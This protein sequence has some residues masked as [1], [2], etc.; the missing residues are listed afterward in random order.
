M[1]SLVKNP[2]TNSVPSE[3]HIPVLLQEVV[4]GLNLA[5][6]VHCLDATVGS[7]GHTRALLT[8]TAPKGRVLGFDRDRSALLSAEE[9]LKEFGNRF[10]GMHD[11]Y[12][13][14]LQHEECQKERGKLAGILIDLGLSSVQLDIAERGF[15]FRFNAPLDMRF[16]QTHG[17]T[18]ADLLNS[19]PEE[20]L[21][22]V[23]WKFGEEPHARRLAAAIFHERTR[24]PFETTEQLV[25]LVLTVKGKGRSSSRSTKVHPA[26]QVFQALRITVN[27]ELEHLTKF[28]PIGLELLS[29][30]GRMAI[31]AY[32]SLEDRIVKQF[33][34]D[35]A[36]D[37]VCPP[38]FP[39]CRCNHRAT[40]RRITR[41]PLRPTLAEQR[42]N[43]RSRSARLRI[44]EKI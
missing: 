34:V 31:I 22:N 21:R 27:H 17:A 29:P 9:A 38:T 1:T 44:I 6:N 20:E 43:P 11:S 3:M 28:L 39:E 40:V 35:A 24:Q 8:A 14:A 4:A 2:K 33:F 5:P 41:K 7:G 30:G 25:D 18:A 32:H 23:L 42:R 12:A 26:T 36:N 15:S 13:N 16:D 37:C 19:W 10:I